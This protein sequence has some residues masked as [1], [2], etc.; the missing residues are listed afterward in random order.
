MRNKT[1]LN[2]INET[3]HKMSQIYPNFMK[4]KLD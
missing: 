2:K 3:R 4:I 1:T